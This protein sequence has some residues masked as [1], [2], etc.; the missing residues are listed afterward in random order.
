[1]H[2]GY[3]LI[4]TEVYRFIDLEKFDK[5]GHTGGCQA[6]YTVTAPITDPTCANVTLPP[7]LSVDAQVKNGPMSRYGWIEQVGSSP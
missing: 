3:T 1:M 7:L 6:T 2:G 5:N 4:S